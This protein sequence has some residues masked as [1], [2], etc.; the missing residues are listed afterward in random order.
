M[1]ALAT[2]QGRSRLQPQTS[3]SAVNFC[4]VASHTRIPQ[5]RQAGGSAVVSKEGLASIRRCL[6]LAVLTLQA[7][8]LPRAPLTQP[9]RGLPKRSA[10]PHSPPTPCQGPPDLRGTFQAAQRG[11]RAPRTSF[12]WPQ[13]PAHLHQSLRSQDYSGLDASGPSSTSL[14]SRR[15]HGPAPS[16]PGSAALLRRPFLARHQASLFP[17]PL[18]LF[19]HVS[20]G[21]ES[22]LGQ[23]WGFSHL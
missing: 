15:L 5:P 12:L 18:E 6:P 17:W 9:H 22:P 23:W 7:A 10:N 14:R 21:G 1:R 2:R 19:S 13:G 16:G 8:F 3:R 11:G 4:S 20:Y